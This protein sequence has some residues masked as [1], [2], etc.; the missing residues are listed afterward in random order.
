M[1][2]QLD[3]LARFQAHME[4]QLSGLSSDYRTQAARAGETLST[5][6]LQAFF[7]TAR[8]FYREAMWEAYG[9]EVVFELTLQTAQGASKT[10]YGIIIGELGAG[11]WPGAVSFPGGVAAIL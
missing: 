3:A 11:V 2:G 7:R 5:E 4:L 8:Q 1:A 9:D 6:G 10:L